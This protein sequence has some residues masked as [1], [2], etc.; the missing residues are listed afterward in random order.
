VLGK[1]AP[2]SANMLIRI[3]AAIITQSPFAACLDDERMSSLVDSRQRFVNGRLG[4]NNMINGVNRPIILVF[5][6]IRVIDGTF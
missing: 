5:Q 3:R 6:A 1:H 2:V 4:R